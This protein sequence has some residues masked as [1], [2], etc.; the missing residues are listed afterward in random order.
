MRQA[1]HLAAAGIVAMET[2]VE[3]LIE[4]HQNAQTLAQGLNKLPGIVIDTVKTPT[5]IIFFKLDHPNMTP[6][7]FLTQMDKQGVKLLL[8]DGGLFRA[9]LNR[10]VT[11][12]NTES[13]I[14]IAKTIL[15]R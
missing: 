8:M 2:Q 11:R 5:N 10:M 4:D 7:G 14:Q 15:E 1:G 9:V 6:K 13:A 12:E 3:R